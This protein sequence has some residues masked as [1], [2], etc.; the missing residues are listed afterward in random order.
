MGQRELNDTERAFL[1]ALCHDD[2]V[3]VALDLSPETTAALE[4]DQMDPAM[5]D[6]LEG[7]ATSSISSQGQVTN[8]GEQAFGQIEQEDQPPEDVEEEPPPTPPGR[9]EYGR[10]FSNRRGHALQMFDVLN[11]RYKGDWTQWEPETLWWALRRDFGSVG[12]IAR[13]KIMA[14]RVAAITDLTWLDWDTFEDSGLAWNDTIPIFGAYQP[15]D[16]MQAA[17]AVSVLREV[18]DESFDNEVT[19]YIAAILDNHGFVYAPDEYFADA[20][21]LLDRNVDAADLRDRVAQMWETLRDEDP[22]AV[23]F[24]EDD[25]VDIHILKLFT[26]KAYLDA[27]AASRALP[28]RAGAGSTMTAPPVP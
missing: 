21:R 11:S 26:V 25:P 24:N 5:L 20:Q 19:A 10:L 1:D 12:E 16:P 28:M 14:L 2:G 23:D 13:H 27:R 4:L 9:S 3:K 8:E 7:A 22:R 17:F 15:M 6:S 18:R